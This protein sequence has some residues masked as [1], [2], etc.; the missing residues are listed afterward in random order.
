MSN[1]PAISIVIPTFKRVDQTRKT[2]S[3]LYQSAGWNKEYLPEVIIADSTPDNSIENIVSEFLRPS[4]IFIRPE[5]P[6]ISTNKNTGAKKALQEILIFCDSDMEVENDTLI[7]TLMYLKEHPTAAMVGGQVIWR[8]GKLDNQ[9]DR[10]RKEDRMMEI[11]DATYVEAIYSR[12]L[13]TYKSLFWQTGG[14]D[15]EIFNMRGEGSDLSIR[16]WRSGLP[17]AFSQEIR[18][19]HVHEATDTA[20]RKIEHP[21]RGIIRD[22]IQLAYKYGVSQKESPNFAGTLRWLTQQFQDKDKYIILESMVSLL[23]YFWDN[24]EKIEKS[25]QSIPNQYDFKF[26]DVF[27]KRELFEDCIRQAAGKIREARI[28]AFGIES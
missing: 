26:L 2:L 28:V 5:N 9:L 20:T 16:F 25:R 23:P 11:A 14:Y 10:P 8:G 27:T 15:E 6:G 24:R 18:V 13:A 17:L 7:N 1:L 22:L 12:Y 3:L 21:E 19:H 4:P